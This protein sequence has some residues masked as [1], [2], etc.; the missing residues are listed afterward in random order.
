MSVA[1]RRRLRTGLLLAWVLVLL[2]VGGPAAGADPDRVPVRTASHDDYGRLVFD[3]P[4]GGTWKLDRDGDQVVVRL[5]P[6]ATM[7]ATGKPPRN[8]RALSGGADRAELL[9]ASGAVIETSHIGDRLVIDVHDPPAG[10]PPDPHADTH[11]DTHAETHAETHAA[12]HPDKRADKHI[13]THAGKAVAANPPTPPSP[14]AAAA[15]P[16][17]G[18][19]HQAVPRPDGKPRAGKSNHTSAEPPPAETTRAEPPPKPAEPPAPSPAAAPPV[20]LVPDTKP[21]GPE[22]PAARQV[23]VTAAPLP[24][25]QALDGPVSL[26]PLRAALPPAVAGSAIVLPFAHTTGA[27]MY[28]RGSTTIVVFDEVRPIDLKAQRNDRVFGSASIRLL[29]AATLLLLHLPGDRAASLSPTPQ[30]WQVAIL[31]TAPRVAAIVPSQANG[32]ITLAADTPGSVVAIVDPDTGATLMV[33]TQLRSGQGV[34]TP[35]RGAGF[36]LLPTAQGVVVEPLD[37]RVVLRTAASGFFLGAEPDGL[38]L[39]PVAPDD[40]L[41]A[42]ALGLTRRFQF[43]AMPKEA[44]YS[45]LVDQLD[46]IAAVP[47]QAR[48]PR[49]VA[50][51]RSL[52]ALGMGAE[53]QGML[54]IAAAQA[55]LDSLSAEWAGLSGIAAL[56]AGRADQ[57]DGLMDPRLSNNDEVAL[58]RA[59]RGAMRQE[60][61]PRAASIMA[62]T[63]RLVLTY[64][65]PIRRKILPIMLETMILGGEP[66]AASNLLARQ[67]NEPGLDYARALLKEASGDVDGALAGLDAVTQSR[68]QYDS[69]RAAIRAVELRLSSGAIDAREAADRLDKML[70]AWRGDNREL[71]L[72]ERV[73]ELRQQANEWAAALAVRRSIAEDFPDQAVPA[74]AKLLETFAALLKD[75]VAD[76]LPP[77]ELITLVDENADLLPASA[78]G[79]AMQARLADRLLALDLPKR[80]DAVLQKLMISAPTGPSRATYGQRLSAL[81]LREGDPMAAL[82]ALELSK[83][84]ALPDELAEKRTLVFASANARVGNIDI[85]TAALAGLGTAAADDARASILEKAQ[86]WPAAEQALQALVTKTVPAVE[87]LEDTHRRTILRL[88]TAAARGGDSAALMDLRARFGTRMGEGPLANMFRLLTADPVR[89]SG[90]LQRAANE[91]GLTRAISAGLQAAARP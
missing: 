54:Q 39:S 88:A 53:A 79:E 89:A 47:P 16:P 36:T 59:I 67:K 48:G 6:G 82:A 29:P 50:A 43:P 25:Q 12:T 73:A 21:L 81:R 15:A 40:D 87:P 35:R 83:A 77:L 57:S 70:Y 30:G 90:D 14:P 56:L 49:R 38:L 72:R 5:G 9:I 71:D 32:R 10:K 44:L 31:S 20:P 3:L 2:P 80:A 11:P 84:E 4:P 68:D 22:A 62:S 76:R 64:P 69:S 60:G 23:A 34:L 66:K 46:E 27:A 85:A 42:D 8:V 7:G 61:S 13:E 17:A 37:D 91:M 41:V 24:E 55:P 63:A 28:T 65:A 19:A 58:W 78:E 1:A 86:D 18:A 33:G 75:D 45:H 52:L 51:A 74:H 26:Q